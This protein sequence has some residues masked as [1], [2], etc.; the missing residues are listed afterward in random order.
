MHLVDEQDD[1]LGALDFVHD[2][3]DALFELAAVLRAGDHQGEVEG[4][5]L[6]IEEDFRDDARSDLLG[7]AFDDGGLT[8]AGFT[9]EDR[10]ILRAAAED[11][12]HAADFFL[13]S[14]DRIKFS[15][16]GELGE[17][18]AESLEQRQTF[19]TT[20]AGT[21]FAR[22]AAR[23]GRSVVGGILR[24]RRGVG[25]LF[26]GFVGGGGIDVGEDF[27]AAA[28]QVDVELLQDAGGDALPFLQEAKE[29]MFGANVSVAECAGLRDG[30]SHDL[31]HAGRERNRVGGFRLF[32]TRA[33]LLLNGTTHRL[34]IEAHATED[35]NRD[36]LSELDEPEQDV[37]RADVVMIKPASFRPG[38]FHDL[39]GA[40]S[41]IVVFVLIHG[42]WVW[43]ET[44]VWGC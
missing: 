39:T 36:A 9:D 2:A 29:N 27:L 43:G 17:I 4:D 14:D 41:E 5:H 12:H 22:C 1:V 19:A 3:L 38:Q 37:L 20:R 13:T 7:E 32:R 25:I 10:I 35:V 28:F 8:H 42:N 40:G 31:L 44:P 18:S 16:L 11:L 30:V 23:G 15:G 6:T 21:F 33:D 24:G 26:L 34:E